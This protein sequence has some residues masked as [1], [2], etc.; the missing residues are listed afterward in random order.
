MSLFP[1]PATMVEK[2]DVQAGEEL[3]L[4]MG[5]LAHDNARGSLTRFREREYGIAVL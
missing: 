5:A 4:I 2:L 3:T 1:F